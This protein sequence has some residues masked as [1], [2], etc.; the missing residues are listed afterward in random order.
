MMTL[1]LY[2]NQEYSSLDTVPNMCTNSEMENYDYLQERISENKYS[3]VSLLPG[4]LISTTDIGLQEGNL[5]DD[6]NFNT[7][8]FNFLKIEN[9]LLQDA[10]ESENFTKANKIKQELL[11]V[12]AATSNSIEDF[13]TMS[14]KY[15]T[16]SNFLSTSNKES[17]DITITMNTNKVYSLKDLTTQCFKKTQSVEN[18][19]FS[20][21]FHTENN[22]D[23]DLNT[24]SNMNKDYNCVRQNVA[25]KFE[26]G[27]NIDCSKQSN[28]NE[29][30]QKCEQCLMMFKYKRHLD[31]HLEGHQKNNCSHC[32]EKFARRKHLEVHLFR[33][34]GEKTVRYPH[35][36]DAC[37][38]SFPK[39]ALL[40]RH[41]DKHS[42]QI[43]KICSKREDMI[44]TD[45]NKKEHKEKHCKRKQFKCQQCSQI[46]SIEQTYLSHLQN[47]DNYKCPNC[48]VSFAS[49]KKAREHFKVAHPLK[50]NEPEPINNGSYFCVNCRHTFIKKDDY[51]RHLESA[52]HLSKCSRRTDLDRHKQ[53]HVEERNVVCEHCGKTFTSVSILKDHV[54]YIHSKERQFICE[55]CG[56]AFKRN[57]LLK[58]HKL[59]H[60]QHR[61]F[62][63]TQCN[64]AFKRSHHLTRHM[65]NCHRITLQKKKKVMKLMKTEDGHLI[66]VP[67]Q[68]KELS[69]LKVKL[70]KK[71]ILVA[72]DEEKEFITVNANKQV[73]N[74]YLQLQVQ[75]LS[76]CK[77]LSQYSNSSLDPT[78]LSVITSN[79]QV[80]SSVDTNT[81]QLL[82]IEVTNPN[83][84]STTE[85]TDQL[86]TNC[87]E[88]LNLSDCQSV[89]FQDTSL[90]AD[91]TYSNSTNHS[92]VSLENIEDLFS[93]INQ[94]LETIN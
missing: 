47:H 26:H 65:E 36:C 66:P 12:S 88:M 31:R 68:P 8:D 76:N 75:S 72:K 9:M 58:R 59:S 16:F 35:V 70:K 25:S 33:A 43:D 93:L 90:N 39:R 46:F 14:L 63:C 48:D 15:N 49:K 1:H 37:P 4:T 87:N 81:G 28:K 53:L 71:R 45:I 80:L 74:T 61:P 62:A 50:L 23:V 30:L 41:K 27:I 55:E 82:T 91:Q 69:S 5:D 13:D 40:K 92:E 18:N 7:I 20:T 73:V 32:N 56:R 79:P 51:S 38:K 89:E 86:G 10:E 94:K 54:L 67:E 77:E 52:L 60:E 3:G 19:D 44:S 57:S 34:H 29:Q 84:L 17:N 42:Y 24:D 78:N 22:Q 64:T 83:L 11:L 21:E 6:V 85:Q 2:D